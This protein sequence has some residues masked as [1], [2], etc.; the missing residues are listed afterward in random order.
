MKNPAA[1][2]CVLLVVGSAWAD[3]PATVVEA[4]LPGSRLTIEQAI[5]DQSEPAAKFAYAAV[6]E[7][8]EKARVM[9]GNMTDNA[10]QKFKII[11]MLAGTPPDGEVTLHY[12]VIAPNEREIAKGQRVIWIVQKLTDSGAFV[13]KAVP[14]TDA[15]RQVVLAALK[16]AGIVVVP[17]SQPAAT[18]PVGTKTSFK[19]WELYV[20]QEKGDEFS[21]CSGV[22]PAWRMRFHSRQ[23]ATSVT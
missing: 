2:L 13:A 9:I 8:L 3:P 20:W 4:S 18:K 7:A 14:D 15:E 22:F 19:S 11:D 17:S 5:K 1:V 10:F 6:C 21:L 16:T 23:I 12:L